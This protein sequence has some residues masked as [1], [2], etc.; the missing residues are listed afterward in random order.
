MVSSKGLPADKYLEMLYLVQANI[1]HIV[2]EQM[3]LIPV[4]MEMLATLII[5]IA[6]ISVA[7]TIFDIYRLYLILFNNTRYNTIEC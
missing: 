7:D 4:T 3:V 6:Q 5:T 2:A 1:I